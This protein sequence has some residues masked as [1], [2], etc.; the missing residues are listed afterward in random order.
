M[1]KCLLAF[2]FAFGCFHSEAQLF[3]SVISPGH[4]NDSLQAVVHAF[5]SNFIDIQGSALQDQGTAEVF[6]SKISL[7]GSTHCVIYRF[8]SEE[9]KHGSWQAILYEGENYQEAVKKYKQ[10]C[11]Q[12]KSSKI[13]GLSGKAGSFRGE[14]EKADESMNFTQ[15]NF[16]LITTDPLYDGLY[17]EV[18][19]TNVYDGWEVHLN[20][21]YRK[22]EKTGKG[23]EDN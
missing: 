16:E 15:S 10:T 14:M 8:H 6:K 5:P 17:T 4:F 22:P 3:R 1:K 19:I 21:H 23:N 18:E 12:V 13:S 20:M 2:V 9:D 7:P 11:R